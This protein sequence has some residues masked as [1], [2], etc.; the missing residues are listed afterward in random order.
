[1]LWLGDIIMMSSA[2][3]NVEGLLNVAGLLGITGLLN[4]AESQEIAGLLRVKVLLIIAQ[5]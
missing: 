3:L 1:L 4:F 5:L 2:L